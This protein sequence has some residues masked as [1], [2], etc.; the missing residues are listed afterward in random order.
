MQKNIKNT[1]NEKEKRIILKILKKS[2]KKLDI[3]AICVYGSRIS[4]YAKEKSD[5]DL[6]V[7]INNYKE[8]I[9]YKYIFNKI[10]I[11]AIFVDKNEIITDANN[12]SMGEFVIGRLINPYQ[13]LL[14]ET[15]F[16][17]IEIEYKKRIIKESIEKLQNTYRSLVIY[18]KIPIEFFLFE[19]LNL[20]MRTYPPVKYSYIMTYGIKDNNI[21]KSL[22]GF[23][24][25]IKK[26]HDENIN[27][28]NGIVRIKINKKINNNLR[29]NFRLIKRIL[30]HYY[31]HMRAGRV[32]INI[33]I[34]EL[35]SKINRNKEMEKIPER[36]ANPRCL[37]EVS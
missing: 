28:N 21:E 22:K 37:L 3:E 27:Y 7:V 4:G 17:N 11:S 26:L 6:I 14:N 15:F 10:D 19:K 36:L 5:Y 32:K 18:L 35:F 23:K 9:R 13:S 31:I 24:V 12:A 1:I 30:I 16:K 29:L 8:K 20:R 33:V 25:A 34:K 2:T